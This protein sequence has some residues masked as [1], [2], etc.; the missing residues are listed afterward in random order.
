MSGANCYIF[1]QQG[2]I[3]RELKTT[4]ILKLKLIV[5]VVVSETAVYVIVVVFI[6]DIIVEISSSV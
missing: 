5:V 4:K 2:A 6:V 3:L 1:H